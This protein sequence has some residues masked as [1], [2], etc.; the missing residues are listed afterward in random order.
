MTQLLGNLFKLSNRVNLTKD[1]S[2]QAGIMERVV[3][4]SHF[5]KT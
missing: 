5:N 1:R 3:S 4:N 2:K